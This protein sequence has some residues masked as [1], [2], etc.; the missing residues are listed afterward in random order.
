MSAVIR[1]AIHTY[2]RTSRM[3]QNG[4]ICLQLFEDIA[5]LVFGKPVLA[6]LQEIAFCMCTHTY[7]C[8]HTHLYTCM[9]PGSFSDPF[10]Q[11]SVKIRI[12]KWRTLSSHFKQQMR[13]IIAKNPGIHGLKGKQ[14][15]HHC[16]KSLH[17]LGK[18]CPQSAKSQA[19]GA[20]H[21]LHAQ[22]PDQCGFST[23]CRVV[24]GQSEAPTAQLLPFLCSSF[25]SLLLFLTF[26]SPGI[27]SQAGSPFRGPVSFPIVIV[28]HFLGLLQETLV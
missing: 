4:I 25:F 17:C 19:R 7:T 3:K 23:L 14:R 11:L 10:F 26:I 13:E 8:T 12:S 1:K 24:K 18:H 28:F 21:S 22:G 15:Y 6:P 2:T 9:F 16:E 20:V 27:T 5:P